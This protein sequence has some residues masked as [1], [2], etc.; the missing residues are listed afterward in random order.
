MPKAGN[1]ELLVLAGSFGGM[2]AFTYVLSHLPTDIYPAIIVLTHLTAN[3]EQSYAEVLEES[4]SH[5][6]YLVKDK[7]PVESGKIYLAPGGYHLFIEDDKTFSLSVD[8]KVH[9]VRPA[10]DVLFESLAYTYQD[11]VMAVILSGANHDGA[12]GI[13]LISEHGGLGII[14]SPQSAEAEVM[15]SAAIASCPECLVTPINRIPETILEYL[16]H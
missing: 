10:A 13:K 2:E 6:I 8:T 3:N 4:T 15:P 5:K 9:H 14:Q 11:K 1:F 12:K 16:M 7:H